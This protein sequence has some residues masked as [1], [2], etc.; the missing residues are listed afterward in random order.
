MKVTSWPI[1][2]LFSRK[3]HVEAEEL[4]NFTLQAE[5]VQILG[6]TR[7]AKIVNGQYGQQCPFLTSLAL[8]WEVYGST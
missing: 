5:A 6:R 4:W 1:F 2:R 7:N 3:D 8:I